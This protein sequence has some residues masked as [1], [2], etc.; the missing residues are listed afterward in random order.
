MRR[1]SM[2]HEVN[3]IQFIFALLGGY[4]G[5]FLGGFDGFLYTLVAFV[6]IDY[7]T[8]VMVAILE[9]RISSNEGAKGIFKKIVIFSLVGIGNLIDM[10]LI[11]EGSAIRTAVVFFYISNEGISILENTTKIGL[12]IPKRLRNILEQLNKGEKEDD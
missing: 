10:Y 3:W 6:T 8:G 5:W 12:P 4:L 9:R 11:K 2:K 1:D 7:I